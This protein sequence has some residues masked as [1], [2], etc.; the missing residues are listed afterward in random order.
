MGKLTLVRH[1][2]ASF[3]AEDYDNLSVLGRLQAERLGEYWA[4]KGKQFDAVYLGTLRRHEQ[5][6]QGILKHLGPQATPE[7]RASLNE[8]DSHAVIS[9]THP[10]P[11]PAR[12]TVEGFKQ[13]F[14][15]LRDGLRQWMDG[16]VQPTGMP[17][18]QAFSDGIMAVT[19]DICREHTGKNVL[20]VSSG[21]PISTVV[22]RLLGTMPETTVELNYQIR[23]TA[24]VEM[25]ITP[26]H[27][28]LMTFN[29]LPH[30]DL[31]GDESMH[32]YA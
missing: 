8:Y 29:G 19:H 4:K 32:T 7:Y 14:R 31:D 15:I 30:L 9:C 12:D 24:L 1:G 26:K 6:L 16:T 13:H 27:L 25:R 11:L 10:A 21:G 18:Y 17:T 22:G 2:Q 20:V 5:T 23:N 28:R 3:L